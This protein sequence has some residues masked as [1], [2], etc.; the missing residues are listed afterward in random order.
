M[1]KSHL[2]LSAASAEHTTHCMVVLTPDFA[3]DLLSW[4]DV[5]EEMQINKGPHVRLCSLNMSFC[6]DVETP[7]LKH[8][9]HIKEGA[10]ERLHQIISPDPPDEWCFEVGA[11][12]WHY[13]RDHSHTIRYGDTHMIV[14]NMGVHWEL[15]TINGPY[16]TANIPWKGL[17]QVY[18]RKPK[19]EA[20]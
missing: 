3:A 1:S 9:D 13:I 8:Y 6:S 5:L 14:T 10:R 15:N 16:F 18:Q 12:D 11:E 4:K 19:L 7:M 17:D 2:I 20:V